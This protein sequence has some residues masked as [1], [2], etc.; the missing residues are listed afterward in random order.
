MATKKPRYRP[1]LATLDN[2]AAE[3]G[4]I[5]RLMR[6]EEIP[7]QHGSKY[8]YV[9]QQMFTMMK[10]IKTSTA[11]EELENKINMLMEGQTS[12][13]TDREIEEIGESLRG[14]RGEA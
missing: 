8:V 12:V 6:N 7:V 1:Q 2:V 9:L 5:Y 14:N 10:D 13:G 3:V 4:K 11:I